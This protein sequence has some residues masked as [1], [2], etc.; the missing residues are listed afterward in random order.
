MLLNPATRCSE[1]I[2]EWQTGIPNVVSCNSNI[3]N[4][5]NRLGGEELMKTHAEPQLLCVF[6]PTE[7]VLQE[8]GRPVMKYHNSEGIFRK[9]DYIEFLALQ[10][11]TVVFSM[12]PYGDQS[13]LED[14]TK[15][16]SWPLQVRVFDTGLDIPEQETRKSMHAIDFV[17]QGRKGMTLFARGE[18]GGEGSFEWQAKQRGE[19]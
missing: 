8:G 16:R 17:K 6:Q 9:G 18:K 14:I 1:G 5:L 19:E 11:M 12:C 15:Q 13:N 2:N 10:D 3:L 7:W 4:E